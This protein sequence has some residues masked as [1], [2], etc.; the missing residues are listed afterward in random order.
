VGRHPAG[1]G[2]S[3]SGLLQIRAIA[4]PGAERAVQAFRQALEILEDSRFL[5]RL[6][7]VF[8]LAR[9]LTFTYPGM[10][11]PVLSDVSLFLPAASVIG[12]VG[13]NGSGK[14]TLLKLLPG[15]YRPAEGKI[16]V[17]GTD[18]AGMDLAAWRSKISAAFQDFQKFQF[19]ARES[20][21]AGDL[22]RIGHEPAVVSALDRAGG[23][24][25]AATLPDGLATQ[26]GQSFAQGHELSGGQW[27]TVALGRAMM[28][29]RHR[30]RK[31]APA[32]RC[33]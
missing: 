15:L 23:Q 21:G 10:D 3:Q 30:V 6:A 33:A 18:L 29:E 9:E 19:L 32:A 28:R 7:D 27:Q 1:N 22:A 2:R 11:R 5:G 17:D 14:S 31:F 13:E 26:L 25:L 24:R 20:V 8:Q 12:L 16:L 4:V